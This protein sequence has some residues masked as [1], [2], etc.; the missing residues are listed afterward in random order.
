MWSRNELIIV[1]SSLNICSVHCREKVI[2]D[3]FIIQSLDLSPA[4]KTKSWRLIPACF[5]AGEIQMELKAFI[6]DTN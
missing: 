3:R 2:S 1:S 6:S 4:L 5:H